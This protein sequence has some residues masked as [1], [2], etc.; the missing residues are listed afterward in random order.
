MLTGI[1]DDN[2]DFG[3]LISNFI[4]SVI[5]VADNLLPRIEIAIDGVIELGV[6]LVQQFLKQLPNIMNAGSDIIF[7]LIDGMTT[8][9]PEISYTAFYIVQEFLSS[10]ISML[11]IILQ[12]GIDLLLELINGITQTLPELIPTAID[13]VIL[14]VETLIDNIDM[15]IDAGIELILALAEGLIEALPRLIEKIPVI[16]EKLINA[17]VNNLPKIIQM[18]VTLIIKLASGLVQAIPQ[19]VAKIPQIISA[20]VSGLANAG[21]QLVNAG[22]NLIKGIWQGMSNTMSWIWGKISGFCNTIVSKIKSFFG[23]HSP[24]KLFNQEIGQSLGLGLGEGFEDSLSGVYKDMQRAVDYE[25]AK[26]TSNL[27]NS[28]QI[29]LMNE[30]NTQ[31]RLASIDNNKEIQVNSTLEVDGNKMASVVNRVNARQKL[32]YGMA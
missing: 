16:I 1:A 14:M 2:A 23:I 13:A 6:Q 22:A 12:I 30:D 31:S 29:S 4:D 26:L 24:S 17:I 10:I 9:I 27:T 19:L 8:M 25:N 20:L 18:G 5:T 15:I 21:G 7:R 32:Q 3:K 28:H 11:P